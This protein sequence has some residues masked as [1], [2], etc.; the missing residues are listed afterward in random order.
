MADIK[1]ITE[2]LE[3]TYPDEISFLEYDSPFQML[4]SVIL[5][6]QTTD[7]QVNRITPE[8]FRKFPDPESLMNADEDDVEAVIKSTGFAKIKSKNIIGTADLLHREY[9]DKVPQDFSDLLRFPGIGRKS[10]NVVRG[11][12]FNLPAIIVDTHF[13]RVVRRLG[14]TERKDPDKVE[15]ELGKKIPESDHMSFSMRINKLG[16]DYCHASKPECPECPL[17]EMCPEVQ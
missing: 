15:S 4:I 11:H 16:R 2:I 8:L 10:A 5:T 12:I 14:L 7:R 13:G 6:A 1:K 3:K 17:N 9:K